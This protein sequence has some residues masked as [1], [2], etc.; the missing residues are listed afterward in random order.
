MAKAAKLSGTV[1][2][3][4]TS[5]IL[6]GISVKLG[7]SIKTTDSQG[8]FKFSVK[9]GTHSLIFTDQKGIYA[10]YEYTE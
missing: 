5:K 9:P 1:K 10:S 4:D 8:A 7:N 3:K 2:A 6:S